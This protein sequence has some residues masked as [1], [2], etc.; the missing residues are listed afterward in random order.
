MKTLTIAALAMLSIV[1]LPFTAHAD[2]VYDARSATTWTY[3][4]THTIILNNGSRPVALIKMSL[5]YINH[6][7]SLSVLTDDLGPYDGKILVDGEV[8]EPSSV[9]RI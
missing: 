7:S 8:C 5:C 9:S 1:V 4:G 3:V 2:Y 6:S